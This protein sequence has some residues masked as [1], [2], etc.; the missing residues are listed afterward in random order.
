[1]RPENIRNV[2]LFGHGGSG[3]TSLAEALLFNAGEINRVGSVDAGNTV[4]DHEPEE[5]E[6]QSSL[7][8]GVASFDHNGTRVNLIDTPGYA[9]FVGEALAALR[10]VDLAVFVVS[11]VDG[12]EV[13][14]EI[15]WEAARLEGIPRVVFV[16]KLDRDRASFSRTLDELVEAFGKRIAPI[17]IPIGEEQSLSGVVRLVSGRAYRYESGRTEGT[18]TDVPAEVAEAFEETRSALVESVVETD[19]DLLEAYFEGE[20]PS[21]ERMVEV[22][23]DGMLAGDI[24]PVLVGSAGSLVGIDTLAEFVVDFGPDPLERTMPATLSGELAPDADGPAVAYTFKTSGDQY[25]GRVNTFRVFSGSFKPDTV[26]ENPGGDKLKMSS[27][28]SLQGKEHTGLPEATVGSIG[29]VA[30]LDRLRVGDTLRAP[31]SAT[32]I[33]PV[34]VPRPVHEVTVSPRSTQDEDKL[35]TALARIQE[36]DPTIMVER[37]AETS[38]TVLS[39]LGEAHVSVTLAKVARLFGVEVDTGVPRIPYRETIQGRADV[40]GKHKKQS[41]G[42]GQFGVAYVRFEPNRRGEGYE[43]VDQIKGGSIPRSLIPAV[44]K[45]IREALE[46]GILAGYRVIDVRAT[47]YDGKFHSVDSD[48]LSFR[49]AGI[50]AVR[51][52][53]PDLRATILE[54]IAVVT[55]RV[56]EDYM[57]DVIG[58]IN[59][60]RGRVLGMDADGRSRVLNVEV[61]MAEVQRYSVDL[62]SMTGGRGSFD[63]EFAR[64]EPAPPQEVQRVVAATKAAAE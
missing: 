25:V 8:L 32:E 7:G 64:Y 23:H 37:R 53:A 4:M 41:G 2:G 51:A 55:I 63:I 48:E 58:D 43:F 40:E 34:R 5:I 6:R 9:D 12:V 20:E 15:L 35:S 10:A 60:K 36:E 61:P 45:G 3:K 59:A 44:D 21:A 18:A 56:P 62:R 31:G 54:P 17:Q 29:S 57:G 50:M 27:L 46:R 33:A 13:Q 39:G 28:F 11:A 14:T 16:N 30:K 47:V 19:D 22:I 52:A 42:R 26:L 49:M 1:M 24:F 38:E